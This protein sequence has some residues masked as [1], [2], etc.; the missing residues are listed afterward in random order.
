MIAALLLGAPAFAGDEDLRQQVEDLQRRV[1]AQSREIEALRTDRA[2]DPAPA[3]PASNQRV[4]FGEPVR[5]DVDEDVDEVVSFGHDVDVLGHVQGDAVSFGGDVRVGRTGQVGGDA[6]SFGGRVQVEDGGQV[7]GNRVAM[8]SPV[9]MPSVKLDPTEAEAPAAGSLHLT[10]DAGSLLTSLYHRIVWML[11]V[12]GASV[13]LV[14]IFPHRVSRVARDLEARPVRSAIVGT[15]ATG[16]LVL[17]AVLFA[18]VTLGLGS[19]LSLLLLGLLGVAWLLGF[20][21][22]AQAVGDRLPVKE[23]PHGRWIALLVGVLLISFLGSLP[24]VGW[25]VVLGASLLGI[26]ASLSTRFGRP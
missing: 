26:G 1:E 10:A 9:G 22:L 19:P 6:V 17:F 15:L 7:E 24:W 21:G 5:V 20:V 18:V 2:A 14:G 23:R 4:G 3:D 13:L 25:M 16:F 12:A 11:S 8:D